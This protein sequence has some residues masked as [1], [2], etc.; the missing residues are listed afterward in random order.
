VFSGLRVTLCN[1]RLYVR[2]YTYIYVFIIYIYLYIYIPRARATLPSPISDAHAIVV[3]PFPF[4]LS[5]HRSATVPSRTSRLLNRKMSR[6]R[7]AKMEIPTR[8]RA[9]SG[10]RERM[11]ERE[12][13]G[14]REGERER[15]IL[16]NCREVRRTRAVDFLRIGRSAA[17]G[18]RDLAGPSARGS[19]TE[20]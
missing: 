20:R 15:A 12:R 6:R 3:S 5:R 8:S 10:K 19:R 9:Q 7:L 17:D 4:P 11:R 14:G 13:E 2:A 1:A 16:G 18:S